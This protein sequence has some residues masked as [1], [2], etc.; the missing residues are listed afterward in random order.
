MG[1]PKF[2]RWISKKYPS[3]ISLCGLQESLEKGTA[4]EFVAREFDA[5]YLDMNGI[6]HNCA[7]GI[8]EAVRERNVIVW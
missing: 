3:I 4:G 8:T 5:I 6:L 2:F 7:F 1:V